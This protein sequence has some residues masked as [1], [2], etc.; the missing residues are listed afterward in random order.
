VITG[1]VI[2]VSG[3]IVDAEGLFGATMFEVVEV[4]EGR[5]IGEV[6]RVSGDVGTMQVYENTSGLRPG[7]AVYCTGHPLSLSLGPGMIGNIYDGIQRPLAALHGQT[8]AFIGRG[9]K[10]EPL[11]TESEWPVSMR[12]RNGDEVEPGQIIATTPE[13]AMIEHR[14]MVPPGMRGVVSDAVD[15]GDYTV[16]QVLCRVG[17]H[18]LTMAQ[19][20]PVRRGRPYG[21]RLGPHRPLVTGQRV[22]DTFFPVGRGGTAAIPGG[23]GTGKTM[24]Q[25]ALAKWADAD[26][27]VYVGCG[28]R[29]NEMTQVL[30]DFPKL[31]DPRSGR[32]LMERTI[33]IA[34]TS[35]MP[36]AAREVSIYT[37]ITVAEY[38]RDMGYHVAVMADSTSR[39]AEALRELGGR[40]EEMPAEEGFPAYLPTRLA[41]FY[42][43]AGAVETLAGAK[44]SV[45]IIGSVSPQGGDF[46]EPVT[47]HTR[48][49]TRCF[50][51][52]NSGL[53]NARHYPAIHW[54]DS[55]SEY[56]GDVAQWWDGIVPGWHELRQEAVDILQREDNL[57]Q[58]VKLV[59]P[60]VLP[61][62]QRLLLVA[63]EIIK[64]GFLQQNAF[65]EVDVYCSPKKQTAMLDAILEF[66]RRGAKVIAKGAPLVRV[67]ELSCRLGLMRAK[68]RVRND[69]EAG[70]A[71]LKRKVMTDFAMLEA[72]YQ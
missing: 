29:G 22:I 18:E 27:I 30:D 65:D 53:A 37:G 5:L 66:Y 46:A 35:N 16:E 52:L 44:A 55:Y 23:F 71:E 39:W 17:G 21:E 47:Q 72:Q 2:R 50:W 54:L 51:A 59:G 60:D 41:Q 19:H 63:A 24:T 62:S 64:V 28:E 34:N 32:P 38:Y 15:N 58:I 56:V 67:T 7:D 36:V 31:T 3:P 13:T 8:G 45:T 42:E 25:H 20:W 26:V 61:D 49:F 57:Q 4:G 14:V 40:L 11:N 1:E 6:I 70:L 43:R 12:V 48:R 33:L 69:D 68:S 10:A 9:Q